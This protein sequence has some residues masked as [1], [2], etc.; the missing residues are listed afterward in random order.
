MTQAAQPDLF[1]QPQQRRVET[2]AAR[3]SDPES[4]HA[5]AAE[6]TKSGARAHQQQLAAAAVRQFPGHTSM[7]LAE[8]A[9]MDRYALARRLPECETAGT[10]KRG[11][12]TTCTITKRKALVWWPA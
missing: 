5:A 3:R 1:S 12:V 2:P 11:A 4:S 8:L 7:E 6:I 9:G 10:V